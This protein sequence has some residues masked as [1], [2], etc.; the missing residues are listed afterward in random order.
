[1][2]LLALLFKTHPSAPLVVAANR[3]EYLARPASDIKIL[4]PGPPRIVGGQDRQAGGTWLAVNENGVVAGLTNMPAAMDPSRK[5]RGE[6]PLLLA[7][8]HSAE[9]AAQAFRSVEAAEFN[10]CWLLAGDRDRLFYLALPREGAVEIRELSAG[11]HVLENGPLNARTPK[12]E[13]TKARIESL[14]TAQESEL[15]DRAGEI[16]ASHELPEGAQA[17]DR[18][19]KQVACVHMGEFGTRSSTIIWLEASGPPRVYH[20]DG[21]PCEAPFRNARGLWL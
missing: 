2:C 1:M 15:V 12:T 18:P 8:A 13:W 7:R 21:P 11:L 3:D 19:Q 9:E 17:V 6:L 4:E 16:L 14:V 20:A 10:P 5:S